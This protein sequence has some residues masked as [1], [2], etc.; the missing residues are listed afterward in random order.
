MLVMGRFPDALP[1]LVQPET[2]IDA[3]TSKAR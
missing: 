2:A 3:M 1:V